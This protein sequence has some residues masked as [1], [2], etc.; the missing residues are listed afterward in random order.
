[1][2][3][4]VKV[5]VI[6]NGVDV[7]YFKKEDGIVK[8]LNSI[9]WVGGTR[10]F[11]NRDSLLW[12]LLE[13]FPL[14]KKE[15][16]DVQFY[17]VGHI[18][19]KNLRGIIDNSQD[20]IISVGR[21]DD[22]RPWVNKSIVYVAPIRSGSGT[23]LKVLNALAMSKAVVTTTIGV[24]GIDATDGRELFIADKAKEFADK[25]VYLL[26]HSE[27][28]DKTGKKGRDLIERKYEWKKILIGFDWIY[29]KTIDSK[30][31]N[32]SKEIF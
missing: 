22:I 18:Y 9:V 20:N 4:K 27:V 17:I 12:F 31:T 5:K 23:K 15:I 19:G 1:M 8:E 10:E 24:E 13:I 30:K 6:T 26:K 7:D 32:L 11:Y 14:I 29:Q 28:V 3:P 25:I 21:V 16:T 2:N